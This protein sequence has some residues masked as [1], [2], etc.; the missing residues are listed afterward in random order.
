MAGI[1][2]I[3]GFLS[4]LITIKNHRGLLFGADTEADT[5][6]VPKARGEDDKEEDEEKKEDEKSER[7]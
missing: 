7:V 2:L 4:A 1:V 6:T 3:S 5:I